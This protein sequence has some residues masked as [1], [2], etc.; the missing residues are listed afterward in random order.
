MLASLMRL[1]AVRPLL[2]T[3]ILGFPIL[4][5]IGVGLFSIFLF[6]LVVFVILPI[7]ICVWLFRKIFRANPRP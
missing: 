2:G 6:K 5:V 4:L 3:V 1:L 7:A